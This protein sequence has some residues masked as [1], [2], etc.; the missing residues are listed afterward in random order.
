MFSTLDLILFLFIHEL[1]FN[2]NKRLESNVIVRNEA[3][4]SEFSSKFTNTIM[5]CIQKKDTKEVQNI[6]ND[7]LIIWR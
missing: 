5:Y 2:L 6:V 1:Y 7:F 3:R 4:K